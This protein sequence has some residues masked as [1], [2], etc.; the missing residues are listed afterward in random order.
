MTTLTA[1]KVARRASTPKASARDGGSLTG[2][3]AMIR[4]ALRRDRLLLPVWIL[5]FTVLAAS[6]AAATAGLYPTRAARVAAAAAANATPALVAMYGKIYDLANLGGIG[7]LKLTVLG[8]VLVAVLTAIL[9]VR[10]TRA[11]EESGRLEL[12]RA[13]VL[14]RSAPLAATL[15]VM[16]GAS[17]VLGGLSALGLIAGGLGMTSS[18]AFGLAWA[19]AGVCFTGVA[20]VMAQITENARTATGLAMAVLGVSFFLR[21]IGD[22]TDGWAYVSW[23][24]PIGWSQ[25]IRPFGGDR[26]WVAIIP[27]LFTVVAVSVA[28]ALNRHR[29]LGAGLVRPRPGPD[30]GAARL[31]S[32]RALAWRLQRGQL[33]AWMAAFALLGLVLGS[34][35]AGVGSL[36]DTPAAKVMITQL[37]GVNE[38][39]SAFLGAELGFVG[40]FVSVYGIQAALRMRTEETAFR[41]EPLLGTSVT[42]IGWCL[43]HLLIALTGS[44]T[45][46]LI[47]GVTAGLSRGAAVG[48]VGGTLATMLGASL[49]RLPAVWLLTGLAVALFGLLPRLVL[50]AWAA[51]VASA[52]LGE[53]GSMMGLPDWVRDVSP[54]SH[55]PNLPGG[56]ME[57]TPTIILTVVAAALVLV[58]V[59]GFRRRD[60][61]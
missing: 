2:T 39:T 55:V 9:T 11:E 57:W 48:D 34:M 60:I 4:L 14:G 1:N 51:L 21:A 10:H 53:F 29:D 59:A 56:T 44:A 6:S 16:M 54:F 19:C 36:I 27:I 13:G 33:F 26:W 32:P 20:A 47:V 38:L 40:I 3:G 23:L 5:V 58:G 24:S 42:R 37:G 30:R 7:M 43:S 50:A 49:V 52:I 46:M 31:R 15:I 12:M 8:A 41:V 25:Q 22:T 35:S 17:V 28:L 61:G 18:L 45:L